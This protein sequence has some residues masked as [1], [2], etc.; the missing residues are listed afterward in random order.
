[1]SI[2]PPVGSEEVEEEDE[3]TKRKDDSGDDVN[4]LRHSDRMSG[5]LFVGLRERRTREKT[6]LKHLDLNTRQVTTQEHL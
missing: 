5:H 3:V 2:K 1:M 4:G 6:L